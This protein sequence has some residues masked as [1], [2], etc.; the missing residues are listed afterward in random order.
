MILDMKGCSVGEAVNR[1]AIPWAMYGG[2][3]L[4]LGGTELQ[5]CTLHLLSL[6]VLRICTD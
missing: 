3:L 2:G 5:L 6:L 4:T 1:L